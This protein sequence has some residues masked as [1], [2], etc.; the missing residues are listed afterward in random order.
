M[1]LDDSS[2]DNVF[3]IVD[4]FSNYFNSNF[5]A[6]T[7][8]LVVEKNQDFPDMGYSLGT[9]HLEYVYADVL[10]YLCKLDPNMNSGPDC[11]PA[12]V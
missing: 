1:Y 5:L 4:L 8:S 3:S 6:S 10:K 11:I 7:T 2:S 12:I 9:I